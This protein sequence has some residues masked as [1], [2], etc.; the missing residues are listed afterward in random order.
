MNTPAAPD[1]LLEVRTYLLKDG[2]HAQFDRVMAEEAIPMLRAVGMDVVAHGRSDHERETRFLI[3][4]YRDRG[5]LESQQNAF[6]GSAAWREGPRQALIDC[7]DTY[8]N[9]LLWMPAEAVDTL[10]TK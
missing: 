4:A 7:I 3:R 1:R 2:M 6:Y 9:T 5:D 10:R 8:L